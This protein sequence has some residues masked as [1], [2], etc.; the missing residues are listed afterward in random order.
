[1]SGPVLSDCHAFNLFNHFKK[2]CEDTSY[3]LNFTDE[4]TKNQIFKSLPFVTQLKGAGTGIHNH[5]SVTL[6]WRHLII[7]NVPL[8]QKEKTAKQDKM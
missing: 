6:E 2:P 3:Y 5:I 1:M 4:E 7:C 8:Y